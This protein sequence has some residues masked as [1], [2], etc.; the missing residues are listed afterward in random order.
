MVGLHSSDP[1]TVYLSA[2]ARVAGLAPD[3]V[4]DALYVRRSLVRILGMRRTLFVVPVDLAGVIDAACTKAL[5]PPQRRLL[6]RMIEEQGIAADGESWLDEVA[7][8]T[9]DALHQMGEAAAMELREIVPRLKE[10]L[11]FGEGKKWGGS[12]GISTRVLFLLATEGKIIRTQPRGSWISGQYRWSPLD[13]WIEG[14][15]SRL[16]PLH[17][18]AELVRRWLGAFGPGTFTDVKWWTGW[19]VRDTRAALES[20]GAVEVRLD[21]GPGLIA[22]DDEEVDTSSSS[23]VALLPSL[24]PTVMGWKERDWYLGDHAPQL[25]DRN[26]NAG[27]TIWVD[28]RIV[29]GWGQGKDG[30]IRTRLLE[31]VA[32]N[33]RA[34]IDD[35]AGVLEAWLGDIRITPRFSSP[36]GKELRA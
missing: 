16:D 3:D 10:S 13:R 11:V 23:W 21:D 12:V 28:G 17:A 30:T 7:A 20:A 31:P 2:M 19:T 29:G 18:R 5:V 36:L 15:W 8:E 9:L 33:A 24:D 34:A 1:A 25:F 27:A 22:P 32:A 4:A 14:G 26:G 35:R 6:V